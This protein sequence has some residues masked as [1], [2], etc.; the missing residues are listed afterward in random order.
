M[1]KYGEDFWLIF[2]LNLTLLKGLFGEFYLTGIAQAW[3]LTVE[4]IFYLTAPLLF[5]LLRKNGL[6][7]LLAAGLFLGIGFSFSLGPK[8]L[9]HDFLKDSYFMLQQTFFGRST[10]FLVGM[11]L[12]R[13]LNPLLKMAAHINLTW[14]GLVSLVAGL[15]ALSQIQ[16]GSYGLETPTGIVLNTLILPLFAIAPLILGLIREKDR[17]TQFFASPV[18]ITLGKAS[19]VFYLIHIGFI[20][21]WL[22]KTNNLYLDT[23]LHLIALTLLSILLFKVFEEPLNKWV[24][25]ILK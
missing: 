10:E 1:D 24:K 4:E 9:P 2:T 6:L 14:L 5:W 8:V 12:A 23:F 19:Y 22:Y 17:L 15:W 11:L 20:T 13:Y 25:N 18:M 7:L 21:K 3:S 16:P